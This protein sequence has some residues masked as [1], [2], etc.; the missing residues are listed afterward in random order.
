MRKYLQVL[1]VLGA[2]FLIVYLKNLRIFDENTE[3]HLVLPGQTVTP[4]QPTTIQTRGIYKD[5]TYAGSVEDAFYG[6]LQ[7]QAVISNGRIVSV[8]PLQ[9]PSDNRT[10]EGINTQA[11]QILEQEVIRAQSAEV[12][13]VSGASDSSPAFIRSL[14]HALSQ[15]K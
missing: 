10:S 12:D 11:L 6:N 15:A 13:I 1:I 5:G 14:S 3:M 2:F 7:V 8:I 9:Y 4:V